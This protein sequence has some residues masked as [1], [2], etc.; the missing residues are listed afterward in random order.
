[1]PLIEKHIYVEGKD[2][3]GF[4][5]SYYVNERGPSRY[6]HKDGTVI[7]RKVKKFR[8]A[9]VK[10]WGNE[11]L[12]TSKPE[13][14]YTWSMGYNLCV[15]RYSAGQGYKYSRFSGSSLNRTSTQLTLYGEIIQRASKDSLALARK[16][17]NK[18]FARRELPPVEV[19]NLLVRKDIE[20]ERRFRERFSAEDAG[21]D[22]GIPIYLHELS[23]RSRG[24]IKD[25]ATA[26]F[27]AAAGEDR[28][29]TR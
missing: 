11:S 7:E 25:K 18:Y 28:K 1:M 5:K 17:A 13:K 9:R 8:K 24:K 10:T 27:R 29:S 12:G 2:G 23:Q 26:F 19:S 3:K 22:I 21:S 16:I 14:G 6:A 20:S 15:G 4:I